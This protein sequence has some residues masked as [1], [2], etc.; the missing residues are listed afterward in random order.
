MNKY[1]TLIG[2]IFSI[3]LV[4]GSILMGGIDAASQYFDFPSVLIVCG[5]TIGTTLMVFNIDK[6]KGLVL[7]FK[8]AFLKSDLDR[9]EEIYQIIHLS[10]K[11]RKNGGLLAIE[12]DIKQLKDPFLS[13]G[14]QLVADNTEPEI[15]Q[16]ILTKE[17]ES[18]VQRHQ[19]SQDIL[20]FMADAAPAFGMI[21]TLIGLVGMLGSLDDPSM[22]GPKMAVALLTTLYGA[23]LANIIFIP[24]GKKLEKTSEE[25]MTIK[26]ALLEGILALQAGNGPSIIEE[27]LKAFLSTKLKT[28]LELRKKGDK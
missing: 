7:I 28:V 9:V 1:N 2:I 27:K 25:E 18:M 8:I 26:E 19:S 17:I 24:L 23:L 15:I 16:S 5:G 22:I 10:N 3:C 6:L 14:F 21:G 4:V 13:K 12:E 20:S 11:A